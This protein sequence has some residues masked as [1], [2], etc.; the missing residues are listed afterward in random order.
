MSR[1]VPCKRRDF[2]QRLRKL[3]FEGQWKEFWAVKLR[4][5]CGT[6]NKCGDSYNFPLLVS[7]RSTFFNY[8]IIQPFWHIRYFI[9]SSY[10]NSSWLR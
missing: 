1:W 7:K 10:P 4:L 2:I 5:M 8:K 3:G 9:I 6:G